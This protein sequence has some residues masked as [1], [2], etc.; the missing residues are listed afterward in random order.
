M[1]ITCAHQLYRDWQ[2]QTAAVAHLVM[3]KREALMAHQGQEYIKELSRVGPLAFAGKRA[4]SQLRVD[5]W[6]SDRNRDSRDGTLRYFEAVLTEAEYGDGNLRTVLEEVQCLVPE[7]ASELIEI[8]DDYGLALDDVVPGSFATLVHARIKR[9]LEVN[10]GW[11]TDP[12]ENCID[13]N[14]GWMEAVLSPQLQLDDKKQEQIDQVEPDQDY[15]TQPVMP[16]GIK[17]LRATPRRPGAP[18][19]L[20]PH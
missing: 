5:Q 18:S 9:I 19:G 8:A 11:D 12:D 10:A 14:E 20:L 1:S 4:C 7:L 15:V 16:P 13:P 2:L 3:R 6:L 17:N